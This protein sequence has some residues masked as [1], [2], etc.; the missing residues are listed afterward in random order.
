MLTSLDISAISHVV[1]TDVA[2]SDILDSFKDI[3]VLTDASDGNSK[4]GVKVT[5]FDQDVGTVG[6]HGD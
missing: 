3:V 1:G 4:P 6:F 2:G 5:V